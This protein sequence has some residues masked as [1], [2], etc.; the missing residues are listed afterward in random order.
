MEKLDLEGLKK[1]QLEIL[2]VVNEFCQKHQINYWLDCGTLIGAIRHKGYIPWDDDIDIGM[3]RSDYDK[4]MKLFNEENSR[5]QFYSIENN[6]DFLVAFGKVLDTKTILYEPNKEQGIKLNINIDVFV[7]DNAPDDEMLCQKMFKKRDM[8]LKLRYAQLYPNFYDK[9]SLKKKIM[10][11][12]LKIYLKLLPKNYYTKKII[13]NSRKYIDCDTKRVGNF[14]SVSKFVG[15]KELFK[16]FIKVEFEGRKYPAPIGYD[17]WLRNIYGDYM[18][19]PPVEK[20]VSH[21][22]FEAYKL[23]DRENGE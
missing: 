12:F 19:L 17:T 4:F 14:T 9:T 1:V 2:D 10:R 6:K 23:E 8:Y 3:L 15:D 11:F 7:Y 13:K 16:E 21:H 5:Y 22:E 18:K 20:R